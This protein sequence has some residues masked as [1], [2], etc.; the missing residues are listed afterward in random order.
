MPAEDFDDPQL[1]DPKNFHRRSC[2][3]LPQQ[4]RY[5]TDCFDRGSIYAACQSAF[6]NHD[7]H[8]KNLH[9]FY[10]GFKGALHEDILWQRTTKR[11]IR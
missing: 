10:F 4:F 2:T 5:L 3:P 6:A 9:C 8:G 1:T 11:R 7:V